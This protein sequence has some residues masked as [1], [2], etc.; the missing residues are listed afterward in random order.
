MSILTPK[1][2]IGFLAGDVARLLRR[3]FEHELEAA[4]L[5]LTVAQARALAYVVAYAGSRQAVIAERMGVEP[6]TLVS[7]LDQL[8]KAGMVERR[9]H[10]QDRR[11]KAVHPTAAAGPMLAR[12]EEVAARIRARA[13]AGLSPGEVAAVLRGLDAIRANLADGGE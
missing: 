6:M 11:A 8:E 4:A 10:P 3:A 13:V 12:L 7:F 5:P 2:S 1:A 9:P